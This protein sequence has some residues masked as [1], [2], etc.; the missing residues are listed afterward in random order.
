MAEARVGWASLPLVRAHMLLS[1]AFV[2]GSLA[3][4]A[5]RQTT[6]PPTSKRPPKR[7]P[8]RPGMA[9]K[10]GQAELEAAIAAA[11][12]GDLERAIARSNDAIEKNPTLE[13]A[14]LLLG[15]SCA[16]KNDSECE[17][18]AYQ[19][20]LEA[21][22]RSARLKK[23][24]GLWYLG[25]GKVGEAV[26]AYEEANQLTGDKEPEYMADLAY[27]Y[28]YAGKLDDAQRLAERAL[29]LDARCFTCAMSLGQASL[30]KRDFP[31]AKGA[32]GKA[33]SMDPKSF[34][35]K[36]GLAK[37][38]FLAGNLDAAADHYGALVDARPEDY[39]L[40]VQSA[41]VSMARGAYKEAAKNLKVVADANPKE[42][43]LLELLL[44]AQT[45]AKDRK[46]AAA[47]KKQL[48]SLGG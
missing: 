4:G 30:S 24:M 33:L 2:A 29:G 39:R 42:K 43:A 22:P 14:Y 45:K 1:I 36:H 47:T 28:V 46:G 26:K 44:E 11:K 12:A 15:S 3:C 18:A 32:Y 20:G 9:S 23:E 37:A 41:Q 5:Q 13:H 35:A 27:A 38:E 6:K 48:R 16:M 17:R 19:R 10:P 31:A 40:R 8:R 34:E 21:I 7:P 25:Q